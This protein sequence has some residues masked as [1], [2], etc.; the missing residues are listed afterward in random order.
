MQFQADTDIDSFLTVKYS[1]RAE[2]HLFHLINAKLKAQS[3]DACDNDKATQEIIFLIFFNL[4]S[5]F[6]IVIE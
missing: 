4:Q 6:S 5:M 1:K 3:H 2:F